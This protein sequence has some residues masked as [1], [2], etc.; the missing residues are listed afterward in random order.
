MY[1][2]DWGLNWP[3]FLAALLT[4]MITGGG[5]DYSLEASVAPRG[6]VCG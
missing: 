2:Y 5:T 3:N 6:Q 1:M 4:V